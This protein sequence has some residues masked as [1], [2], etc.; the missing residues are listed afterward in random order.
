MVERSQETDAV[1]VRA[2]EGGDGGAE[3]VPHGG[4]AET[5][6]LANGV[7]RSGYAVD[8]PGTGHAVEQVGGS[9]SAQP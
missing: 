7:P 6:E 5:A 9:L 3:V 2:E 4:R 1:G 8:Q